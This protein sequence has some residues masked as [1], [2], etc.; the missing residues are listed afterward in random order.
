MSSRPG[1][2]GERVSYHGGWEAQLNSRVL[3]H[4]RVARITHADLFR[5][6]LQSE[7]DPSRRIAVDEPDWPDVELLDE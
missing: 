5:I 1:L 3:Y 6:V 7:E 4:G 2:S